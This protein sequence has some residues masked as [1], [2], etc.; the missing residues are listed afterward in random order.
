M[1]LVALAGV[2]FC[3]AAPADVIMLR[4]GKELSGEVVS[5]S[6]SAIVLRVAISGGTMQRTVNPADVKEIRPEPA[7]SGIT[8]L[9]IPVFGEIGTDVTAA[10]VGK[11]LAEA[12]RLKV[13]RVVLMIDS[14]GGQVAEQIAICD[15]LLAAHD[16]KPVAFVKHAYSAAALI[17]MACP[18]V[19]MHPDGQIGGAVVI[20]PPDKANPMPRPVEENWLSAKPA[21]N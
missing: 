1:R 21:G 2:L 18:T 6:E 11:A 19:V 13:R 16:L 20:Y 4:D 14:P 5:R 17:A 9:E 8:W 7:S 10:G 12:R 15:T 3:L